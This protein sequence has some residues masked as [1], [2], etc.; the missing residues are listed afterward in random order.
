MK[1][2]MFILRNKANLK[3]SCFR[4]A[5]GVIHFNINL[6]RDVKEING[7][8]QVKLVYPKFKNGEAVVRNVTVKPNFGKQSFCT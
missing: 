3:Y 7:I 1:T 5:L 2:V 4:H 6:K 8:K